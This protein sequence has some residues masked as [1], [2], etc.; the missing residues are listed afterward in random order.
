M[1]SPPLVEAQ[2]IYPAVLDPSQLSKQQSSLTTS[3]GGLFQEI[4]PD[5][6]ALL[7]AAPYLQGADKNNLNCILFLTY[8][9]DGLVMMLAQPETYLSPSGPKSSP[10]LHMT[11]EC[12]FIRALA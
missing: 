4:G 3:R 5:V 11:R 8:R 12:H 2:E 6:R 7:G 9:N 1:R 10:L